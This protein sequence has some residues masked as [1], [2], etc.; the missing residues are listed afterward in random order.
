[1]TSLRFALPQTS[2]VSL[3]P[4]SPRGGNR[5]TLDNPARNA[6]PGPLNVLRTATESF[7][8]LAERAELEHNLQRQE[9]WTVGVKETSLEET[10]VWRFGERVLLELDNARDHR[11]AQAWGSIDHHAGAVA[12]ERLSREGHASTARGTMCC[13]T[14]AIRGMASVSPTCR[15]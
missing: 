10:Q 15:R 4:A 2:S 9:R 8:A 13:R 5:P 6:I 1:M 12:V 7:K 3:R 14:T 11:N